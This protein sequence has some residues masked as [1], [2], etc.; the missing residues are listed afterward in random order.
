MPDAYLRSLPLRLTRI[1]SG[2]LNHAVPVAMP[3]AMSVEPT[4][5]A[6]A[7]SAPCVQVWLSAPMT[8]SPGLMSPISGSSA[9]SMPT[10]PTS[11]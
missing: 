11:K 5:V 3:A 1:A 6:N 9:C 10:L 8:A 4:P 2:T 7:P